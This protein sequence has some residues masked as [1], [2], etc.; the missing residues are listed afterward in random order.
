MNDSNEIDIIIMH[1]IED[2]FNY[3][4]NN[5]RDELK[6]MKHDNNMIIRMRMTLTTVVKKTQRKNI[7]TNSFLCRIFVHVCV[8]ASALLLAS[9][10]AT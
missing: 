4:H 3:D 2:N 9:H 5:V 1:S 7:S 8:S 6:S 10:Y